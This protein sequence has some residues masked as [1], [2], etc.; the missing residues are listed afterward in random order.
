MKKPINTTLQ[1]HDN[2]FAFLAHA[3]MGGSSAAIEHQ[4][5]R[6]QREL[7]NSEAIPYRGSNGKDRTILESWGFKFGE[8]DGE[9]LFIE[10]AMPAG[11]K[12]VRTDHSMWSNLL[13]DKGRIRASIFYKAA[14]Y[15]RDAFMR[16]YTRYVIRRKYND[17]DL[18]YGPTGVEVRDG[19]AVLFSVPFPK[20]L[21]KD[22][23]RDARLQRYKK[24]EELDAKALAWLEV[25]YP[26][27][28]NAGAYWE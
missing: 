8:H 17:N 2:P 21:P 22:A 27:Y 16:L 1:M 12:K 15:D 25:H 10:V 6:G 14:F 28:K 3:M 5:A 13:D 26:N 4:E 18:A 19:D 24:E 20:S 9:D 23:N 7:V 11:W